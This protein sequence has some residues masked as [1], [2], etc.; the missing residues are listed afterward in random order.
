MP[1][2]DSTDPYAKYLRKPAEDSAAD[3]YAKYLRKP[4]AAP[5]AAP[6]PAAAATPQAPSFL[7]SMGAAAKTMLMPTQMMPESWKAGIGHGLDA[8]GM[9][10]L[11][12]VLSKP[13]VQL[14][15]G[16]PGSE[17]GVA[18]EEFLPK[19]EPYVQKGMSVMDRLT[20][21]GKEIA[22]KQAAAR[23]G[24]EAATAKNISTDREAVQHLAEKRAEV[25]AENAVMRQQG[26]QREN[27]KQ[28][29]EQIKPTLRKH[30]QDVTDS[31]FDNLNQR[32]DMVRE[33][34]GDIVKANNEKLQAGMNEALGKVS[35]A[36]QDL[37]QKIVNTS[38][39]KANITTLG[40]KD[41]QAAYSNLGARL[42]KGGLPGDVYRGLEAFQDVLGSEME[43]MAQSQG[44][45][46]DYNM[47]RKDWSQ[48]MTDLRDVRK[49]PIAR[50]LAKDDPKFAAKA[51]EGPLTGPAGKAQRTW[52]KYQKFGAN[53]Y[54]P[55]KYRSML[56]ELKSLPRST[57]LKELPAEQIE[58]KYTPGPSTLTHEQKQKIRDERMNTLLKWAAGIGG[59]ALIGGGGA[60][61][62]KRWIGGGPRPGAPP[63][64]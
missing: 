6:P 59:T 3:P 50:A 11:G 9:N 46:D 63:G 4:A 28:M 23:E 21:A 34:V 36:N 43:E 2:G 61:L 13:E 32:W 60:E 18:A 1:N 27:L 37:F 29:T 38:F 26:A 57:T 24:Q 47:V 39:G 62:M 20:G 44:A 31:V 33:K 42:A 17:A 10:K 15:T 19:A 35:G 16:M 49:S 8:M 53:S 54:L 48:A 56:E 7:Q 30:L 58:S 52:A 45:R 5:P 14:A 22:E 55:T 12:A 51:F 64:P 41:A 25:E 40:W